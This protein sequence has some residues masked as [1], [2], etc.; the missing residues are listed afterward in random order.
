MLRKRRD[1]SADSSSLEVEVEDEVAQLEVTVPSRGQ[2]SYR[3]QTLT[4]VRNSLA[5]L[6]EPSQR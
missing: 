4:E 6:A 5:W 2:I 3:N 1:S